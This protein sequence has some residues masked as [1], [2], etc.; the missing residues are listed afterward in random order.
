MC[1]PTQEV[2]EVDV[3]VFAVVAVSEA[4]IVQIRPRRHRSKVPVAATKVSDRE[5]PPV[6]DLWKGL[7]NFLSRTLSSR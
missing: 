5:I 6:S 2:G 4:K 3:A 7:A 1:F